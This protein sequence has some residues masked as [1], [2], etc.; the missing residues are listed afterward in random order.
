[1]IIPDKLALLITPAVFGILY[2]VSSFAEQAEE[3]PSDVER[4]KYNNPGLVV[5]LGVGLWAQPI[6]VDTVGDGQWDL[7]VA[8][9]DH[10]YTGTYL[11]INPRDGSDF[12]VFAP[13]VRIADGGSNIQASY[14]DGQPRVVRQ[15][16]EFVDFFEKGM[17]APQR[18][19]TQGKIRDGWDRSNRW[20]YVDYDGD[21]VTDVVV[22]I[23]DW[24]DYREPRVHYAFDEEG[25]WTNG[26]IHGYVY[27]LRNTGTDEKPVYAKPEQVMAGGEP[28]DVYGN[29]TGLFADF[30]GTG[31][32]DLICGEMLDG[33]TY[34]ENIGTRTEP[35]YAPGRPLQTLDGERIATDLE[36]IV[37]VAVD[38]NGNGFPDLIV[39]EEDGRVCLI[40]NTGQRSPNGGPAFKQPRY[41]Q[42]QADEINLGAVN[43][44]IGVDWN[45][46]GS[47]DIISGNS[48]GYILFVENL[49]EPGVERPVWA[50]P[51]YLE[52]DGEVIRIM[53]G[54]KGSIQGPVEAKWGYTSPTVADWDGD[55]LL[56][57]VTGSVLGE[58]VWYRNIGTDTEPKLAAAQPIEV[59]WEGE[60]PSMPWGWMKPKGKALLTQWRSTPVAVDWT[61]DGLVDLIAVDQQGVV[62]LYER[63]MLDDGTLVLLPPRAALVNEKGEP[64]RFMNYEVDPPRGYIG[65]KKFCV[66]DWDQDGK[67]DLLVS[68]QPA[69]WL[70]QVGRHGDQ[71]VMKGMGQLSTADLG[72]HDPTP[73]VVDWNDDGYPDLI[74]GVEGGQVYY[75]RNPISDTQ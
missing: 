64:I 23:D 1:M 39:G 26:P 58:I 8:C 55:G 71:Y 28:V 72:G 10:A 44:P 7:A 21:G 51:Q 31:K 13:G 3:A 19:P 69:L 73:G 61:G 20:S 25:N 16:V 41:L 33:F 32:L 65:C 9:V 4:V 42:Q 56:D 37:P 60:Q 54:E 52:A 22:G 45:G 68:N 74:I 30:A 46:D 67:L 12:S 48:A 57:I 14:P 75:K 38:W 70:K 5:D 27:V 17:T 18:I 66:T 35:R 62:S 29:P 47:I 63:K 15:G 43:T 6:P 36:L 34:F 40:E 24:N 11:F 2:T 59:E 50:A 49:S 53:A